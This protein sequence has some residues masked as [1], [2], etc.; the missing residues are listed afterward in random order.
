MSIRMRK[1]T[2]CVYGMYIVYTNINDRVV[3]LSPVRYYRNLMKK[4]G[5]L[6]ISIHYRSFR[7]FQLSFITLLRL[8][9]SALVGNPALPSY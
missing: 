6:K 3:Y 2:C 9:Y 8:F 4:S 1:G 7:T 5:E